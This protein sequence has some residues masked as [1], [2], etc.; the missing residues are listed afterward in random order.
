MLWQVKTVAKKGLT[1][2]L[3]TTLTL[4]SLTEL[5]TLP[6]KIMEHLT[7][8]VG[9]QLH[10]WDGQESVITFQTYL[11]PELTPTLPSSPS[12][13]GCENPGEL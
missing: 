5:A 1:S 9:R 4:T 13:S 7:Q 6:D 11:K 8:L 2:P 3:P 10:H 12:C